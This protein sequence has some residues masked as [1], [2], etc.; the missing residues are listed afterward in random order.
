MT[1]ISYLLVSLCV[2][3]VQST[4][5][6]SLAIQGVY[7]DFCLIL[8]CVVGFLF[9]EYKGL[10]VGI[11]V[12]LLQDFLSPGGLGVNM[13]LKGLAGALGG[14]VT[15]TVS[16]VTGPAILVGTWVLSLGYGLAALV[17]ALPDIN[18]T[19]LVYTLTT[20]LLPQSI[21]NSLLALGCFWIIKKY[22]QPKNL[23][24]LWNRH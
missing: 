17:I 9:G 16:T 1:I 4:L 10:A 6:T 3:I 24:E 8:A 23:V 13:V 2:V 5:S 21:Y 22:H 11:T 20:F 19:T 12:G 18:T 15:H 7:P 14:V